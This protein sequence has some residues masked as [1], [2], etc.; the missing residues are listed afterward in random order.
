MI[1]MLLSRK[2]LERKN[3]SECEATK[4]RFAQWRG[5]AATMT[6]EEI[7]E[8]LKNYRLSLPV[9]DDSTHD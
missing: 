4:A 8:N 1:S 3:Q 6:P 2:I 7:M 9:P 5:E